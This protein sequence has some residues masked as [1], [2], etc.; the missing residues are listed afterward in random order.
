MNTKIDL[1]NDTAAVRMVQESPGYVMNTFY[2]SLLKADGQ[3]NVVSS[4]AQFTQ[5]YSSYYS[6]GSRSR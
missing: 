1:T 2:L 4:V 6:N 3:W 5:L